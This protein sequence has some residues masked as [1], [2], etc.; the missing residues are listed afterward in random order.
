MKIYVDCYKGNRKIWIKLTQI[1]AHIHDHPTKDEISN[2]TPI[3][4]ILLHN[5]FLD[6]KLAL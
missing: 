6:I 3:F 2:I 1:K 5:V 4:D